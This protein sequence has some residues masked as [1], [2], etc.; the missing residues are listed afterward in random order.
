MSAV[1][2][3]AIVVMWA[4]VLVPMWLRRH[5]AA[6]ESRSVDRFSTAMRTLSRRTTSGPGRRYVVMPRRSEGGVSV[7]VSGAAV[8]P[9]PPAKPAKAAVKSAR[10]ARQSSSRRSLVARR[11]RL[12]L[13]LIGLSVFTML[14]AAVGV[15]SWVLQIVFDVI[16]IAFCIHLRGQV[17]RAATTSRQ[18]RRAAGAPTRRPAGRAVTQPGAPVRSRPAAAGAAAFDE[19]LEATGTDDDTWEPVRIPPPTYTLKPPAPVEVP[20]DIVDPLR[21]TDP[22]NTM[23]AIYEEPLAPGSEVIA[24]EPEV[25]DSDLEDILDRRWAVND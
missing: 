11:R 14:L 21:D 1:I 19:P 24:A 8:P 23:A 13:G 10:P 7:H 25:V 22:Y 9:A 18:R 4:V 20:T 16:L 12:F 3:A 17:K 15:I 2:F 5:D 6:T